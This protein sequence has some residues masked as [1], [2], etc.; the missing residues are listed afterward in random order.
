MIKLPQH[1]C[2]KPKTQELTNLSGFIKILEESKA[3]ASRKKSRPG[4]L[5]LIIIDQGVL[6][7][8]AAKPMTSGL[9]SGLHAAGLAFLECTEG[10][11]KSLPASDAGEDSTH[12][13]DANNLHQLLVELIL[14]IMSG[15]PMLAELDADVDQGAC[16]LGHSHCGQR[17]DEESDC[18]KKQHLQ[19]A[20]TLYQ[21][22]EHCTACDAA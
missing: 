8:T 16:Q 12:G 21:C 11:K 1:P 5:A 19:E 3:I 17:A 10:G 20:F 7:L 15:L 6:I 2:C 14:S 22:M 13:Q 9:R 18:G 4:V